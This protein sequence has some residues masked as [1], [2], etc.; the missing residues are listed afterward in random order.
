M[1]TFGCLNCIMSC[2]LQKIAKGTNGIAIIIMLLALQ[3]IT[4]EQQSIMEMFGMVGVVL[5]AEVE[6]VQEVV[7][8]R[9]E[10]EVMVVSLVDSMTMVN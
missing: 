10:A 3:E 1:P 9:V 8:F 4:M 2:G 5:V 6:A 7:G